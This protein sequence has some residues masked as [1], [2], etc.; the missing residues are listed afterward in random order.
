MSKIAVIGTGIS[1]LAAAYLLNRKHEITLFE[2]EAR[3]GGHSRTVTVRHADRIIPVD[4]GFIVFNERNYP[5]LTALFREL[6]VP[7]K[8]S[9]MT[10]AM[11][12][13]DGA[14]E[15]GARDL[16]TIFGQRRN[17]FN[18]AFY[19]LFREVMIFNGKAAQAVRDNPDITLGELMVDMGLSDNFRQLYLLPMS[20]AIWSSPPR[21]MLAFPARVFVDFFANHGL[22]AMSGQP[23]WRTVDGGSQEYVSRIARI[24]G[25]RLRTSAAVTEVARHPDHVDVRD[26][27]GEVHRFD[28]VIFACHSDEALALLHDASAAERSALQAIRYQRNEALLHRD[29]R[30]M[31]RRRRCWSS[32]NYK[33]DGKGNEPSVSVTYW[34]NRL[35]GIDERYPLFV[36]LNPWTPI[37]DEDVFDRHIFHHPVFD[38]QAIRAQ[39]HLAGMQGQNRTWFCGA[40][41]RHGF[42]EDGLHSALKV[43]ER[44][45]CKPDWAVLG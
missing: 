23:Q 45:D 21:Q 42:H 26:Q 30:C 25:D 22:L 1:G 32:W 4:T 24:L 2:R 18:P 15:W 12:V 17:L 34:M 41:M 44:L 35:Q 5:N 28:Q 39:G 14:F 13:G 27:S 36:T 33:S 40:Y 7:V 11:S 9:D 19:R 3:P 43:V 10:Y 31:P 20:G 16:N 6:D 8:D 37:A 38:T 29:P